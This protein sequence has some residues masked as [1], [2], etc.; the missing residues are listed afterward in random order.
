MKTLNDGLLFPIYATCPIRLILQYFITRII[1]GEKQRALS[2]SSCSLFH[3]K[4]LYDLYESVEQFSI[5]MCFVTLLLPPLIS[6]L[7]TPYHLLV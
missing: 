5:V 7:T 6:Y 3:S 1:F 4:E 2:S